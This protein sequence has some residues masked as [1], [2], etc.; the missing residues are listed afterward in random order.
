MRVPIFLTLLVLA[1]AV[2]RAQEPRPIP[3]AVVDLRGFSSGLG[4]DPITAA[5]LGVAATSLPKR[6]IGGVMGVQVYPIRK[7]SLALGIGAEALIARGR[8]QPV[9]ATTGD[10]VGL[11]I[12]QRLISVSPQLSLNFGHREGWSYL[13]AG[14][15]PLTFETFQGAAAPSE[16]PARKN[17]INMGGGARWFNF[18]HLAFTF[19]VRF[20]QTRPEPATAVHPGR[21]R[22]KL[23]V[24][25]AGVAF[26]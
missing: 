7:G 20:Y 4:Q 6:G 9:D 14:M 3:P 17:T 22:S 5:D 23:L 11:P 21:Q 2:A 13:T 26:K 8:S 19:D 18:R 10:P 16:A 1:P 24:M 25:S 12:E 15:G